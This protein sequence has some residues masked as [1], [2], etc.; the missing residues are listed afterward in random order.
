MSDLV[1]E[2]IDAALCEDTLSVLRSA[3]FELLRRKGVDRQAAR[4]FAL[5]ESE[6]RRE[7][8][9]FVGA[10]AALLASL[11]WD[12]LG[13]LGVSLRLAL[14]DAPDDL[15]ERFIFEFEPFYPNGLI[16]TPNRAVSASADN[17]ESMK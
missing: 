9:R 17:L 7:L 1:T 11:E 15:S 5:L 10:D 13:D 14:D 2:K 12:D 8:A 6:K 4:L 3:R 16:R